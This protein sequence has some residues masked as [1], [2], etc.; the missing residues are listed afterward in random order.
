[1]ARRRV[2][3]KAKGNILFLTGASVVAFFVLVALFAPFIAT[4]DPAYIDFKSVLLPP[5]S[6]YYFGTDELGRDIF[7]RVVYG[8]RI[9]LFVGFVAVGISVII[10]TVLGLISG[11]FGGFIDTV[12]MRFVDIML[13]FPSFFLILAVIA[14]LNPSVFNVMAVIGLTSWMGVTRLVRAEVMS[15]RTRDYITA[16]RVQGV[17]TAK[18]LFKH[19]FP[20]VFTPIFITATLGIAG[21]ILTES[22]LSFLGLGVQPPVP[23]WGNILTAGKDNIIFAWWL[24]FFPG[25][26]IF[27]TVLGYNLL[28]EGLRD[29]LD[30]KE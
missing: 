17:S 3:D 19:I 10:G 23:S 6:E 24:S 1:M 15:V 29:V 20:N 8:T 27:I 13:C 22:A 9:S 21:A 2:A 11:Y 28:G 7:S 30:P 25:M 12:L 26:A 5:S 18:I 16:A 4:H 14:F